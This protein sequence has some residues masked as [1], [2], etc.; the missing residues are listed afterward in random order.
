MGALAFLARAIDRFNQTVGMSVA[1]FALFMVIVQFVVV[2][3]RYVFGYGTVFMQESI[4]YMHGFL[5]LLG[6]GYTLLHDGH[7]RVDVFYRDASPKKKAAVNLFGL[8]SLLFPV[9]ICMWFYMWPYVANSWEILESSKETSGIPAVFV[10]KT[11][12]QAFL[13]LIMLQG[14]SMAIHSI[15][16]LAGDEEIPNDEEHEGL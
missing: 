13:L 14:I 16:Q 12:M 9:C 1:W 5:F 10:L 8:V 4:I 15:R 2:V 11:A 6:A 3:L 7:V